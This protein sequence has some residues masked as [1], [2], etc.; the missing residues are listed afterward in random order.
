M[1][2]LLAEILIYY[3][4]GSM[5]QI[6]T[7]SGWKMYAEPLLYNHSRSGEIYDARLEI[8]GW[9]LSNFN[10]EGWEG[11]RVT[12]DPDG[13]LNYENENVLNQSLNRIQSD[14]YILKGTEEETWESMFTYHGF[15]YFQIEETPK[16]PEVTAKRIHTDLETIGDFQCS[17]EMLNQIHRASVRSTLTNCFGIPT[18]CPQ[19][20][21]LGWTGDAA[22][23]AEQSIMKLLGKDPT[24]YRE[25]VQRIRQAY[26]RNYILPQAPDMDSQSAIA[27]GIYHGMY[28]Q[29]DIPAAVNRLVQLIEEDQEHFHTG[30]LGTKAMFTVLTENG[31]ADF[32][33]RMITNPTMPSY[34]YWIRQGMTTLC[35]HWNMTA[36]RNYHMFSEV[37]FWFYKYLAGIQIQ[38]EEINL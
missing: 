19:R 25:L 32:L 34:A 20:E 15:R 33:Y 36:S 8:E 18:D 17:D 9:N 13:T 3:K 7:D 31:Y 5:E 16:I 29:K 24:N 27:C 37:D 1:P 23:S 11:G 22:I 6:A 30:I 2:K 4:D 14:E 35:E 10:E 38:R 12:N 28:E 26:Y 21:Q